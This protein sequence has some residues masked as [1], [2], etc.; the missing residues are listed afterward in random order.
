MKGAGGQRGKHPQRGRH[1]C[2]TLLAT[3]TAHVQH[4][5]THVA[6]HHY[7]PYRSC[8]TWIDPVH[9]TTG[10]HLP[11]SG[12]LCPACLASHKFFL[13]LTSSTVSVDRGHSPTPLPYIADA[14]PL[15]CP[16]AVHHPPGGHHPC[17]ACPYTSPGAWRPRGTPPPAAEEGEVMGGNG[18]CWQLTG[19][20]VWHAA[21]ARGTA[22]GVRAGPHSLLQRRE[23]AGGSGQCWRPTGHVVW[24]ACARGTAR[25]VNCAA[26]TEREAQ[27]QHAG[28]HGG[29][30]HP[31]P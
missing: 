23:V 31:K 10:G 29:R 1:P 7:C 18:Q 12:R 6:G 11:T 27:D 20:V 16:Q 3:I 28:R 30:K 25:G 5:L 19:H 15:P 21:C 22:R 2:P 13:L 26:T 24:H 17:P 14:I 8:P 9:N 4:G